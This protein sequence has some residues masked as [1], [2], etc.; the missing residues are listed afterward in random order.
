MPSLNNLTP[1]EVKLANTLSHATI[2]SKQWKLYSGWQEKI[3]RMN[4]EEVWALDAFCTQLQ[5]VR[6]LGVMSSLRLAEYLAT[7]VNTYLVDTGETFRSS[8]DPDASVTA[9][10][11]EKLSQRDRANGW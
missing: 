9:A 10:R 4:R 8:G 2:G 3:N 1:I 7:V 5:N 11:D 6:G